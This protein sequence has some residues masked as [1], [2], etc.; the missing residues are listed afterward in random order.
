MFSSLVNLLFPPTCIFCKKPLLPQEVKN[1]LCVSCLAN[2][3]FFTEPGCPL[4]A[5]QIGY[6]L[7]CTQLGQKPF[8]FSGTTAL[9][10]YGGDLKNCLHRL[11]YGGSSHL[12]KPLG[13]LMARAVC[14]QE[15]WPQFS[16]VVPIPLHPRRLRERGY[17]QSY[18][19]AR[20]VASAL[21]VPIADILERRI[22]TP[23]Q[24]KLPRKERLSNMKGA[25]SLKSFSTSPSFFSTL[26]LRRPLS[27]HTSTAQTF[28]SEQIILL[29][30][31]IFTTGSTLEAAAAELISRGAAGRVYTAVAAR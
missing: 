7:C 24:T 1:F 15:T 25:F 2:A 5:G 31:D 20:E 11:K 10:L 26:L 21:K 8:S 18:L 3:P 14:Q 6:S 23:P 19:L 13:Q 29:V 9:G 22:N 28:P 16:A 27:Q 12:A 4:C 17:N 30:D